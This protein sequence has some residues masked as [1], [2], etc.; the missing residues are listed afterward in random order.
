MALVEQKMVVR[1]EED[2][3][4]DGHPELYDELYNDDED[5]GV[6]EDEDDLDWHQEKIHHIVENVF[7][8]D[9]E[10]NVDRHD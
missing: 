1:V 2:G 10:G 6:G 5:E 9:G 8:I 4:K 3:G 7:E